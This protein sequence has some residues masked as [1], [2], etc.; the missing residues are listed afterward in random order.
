MTLVLTPIS[1]SCRAVPSVPD[2]ADTDDEDSYIQVVLPVWP[3]NQSIDWW[4]WLVACGPHMTQPTTQAS[5]QGNYHLSAVESPRNEPVSLA[6]SIASYIIM[7]SSYHRLSAP[8]P[9]TR[10]YRHTRLCCTK[11]HTLLCTRYATILLRSK[12]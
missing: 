10:I 8:R 7:A 11:L 6:K 3:S 1:C 5:P 2:N 9:C 12:Q 4:H